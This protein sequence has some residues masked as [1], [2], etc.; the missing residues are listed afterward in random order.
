MLE[1]TIS[2]ATAL[3]HKERERELLQ[4]HYDA[5]VA[6]GGKVQVLNQ[7]DSSGNLEEAMQLCRKK[8]RIQASESNAP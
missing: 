8:R 1:P 7:G 2:A 5:F 3:K 6:R 4:Q